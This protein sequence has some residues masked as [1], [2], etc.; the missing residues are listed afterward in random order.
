[1]V[2][3]EFKTLVDEARLVPK[4]L[5]TQAQVEWIFSRVNIG[6]WQRLDPVVFPPETYTF[7]ASQPDSKEW[8]NALQNQY[9]DFVALREALAAFASYAVKNPFTSLADKLSD[10]CTAYIFTSADI[11]KTVKALSA[12]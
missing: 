4:N 10:F 7:G 3:S 5:V 12:L 8:T 9:I 1:M 11:I 2:Y 6:M